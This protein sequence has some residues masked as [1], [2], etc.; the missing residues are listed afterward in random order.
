METFILYHNNPN[1]KKLEE[2]CEV[3]KVY[4]DSDKS[5][6]KDKYQLKDFFEDNR[7]RIFDQMS[8]YFRIEYIEK[9]GLNKKVNELTADDLVIDMTLP[10]PLQLII[11]KRFV[12]YTICAKNTIFQEPVSDITAFENAQIRSAIR[13]DVVR[14]LTRRDVKKQANTCSVIGFFKTLYYNKMDSSDK[15]IGASDGI[16]QTK[17]S[18]TDISKFILSLNTSVGEQGGSFSFSLP[19]VPMYH[20]WDMNKGFSS[21]SDNYKKDAVASEVDI[22]AI[23][24]EIYS[25]SGNE[26]YPVVKSQLDSMDYF[27]WLIAPNDLMFISFDDVNREYIK[28]SDMA[29]NT[30]DMIGL[31]ESVSLTRDSNGN[32]TVNVSGKDLMKLLSDD[33][34]IFFPNASVID[35]G[36]FFDNTEGSLRTG[37]LAG[38]GTVN[39]TVADK[40]GSKRSIIRMPSTGSVRLFNEECNGFTIDYIIK[41]VIMELTNMQICPSELFQSW[42]KNRTT[43]SYLNPKNEKKENV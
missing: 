14:F 28:D 19:H 22:D 10:C 15:E 41:V 40:A 25:I 33:S 7:Q 11:P 1:V 5:D 34:S 13:E 2:F 12:T 37:D 27:N 38:V 36:N 8:M 30:F 9:M 17:S 3:S 6:K 4:F 32:L 39:G 29:M 42:G 35:A 21:S 24:K 43:F 31:V 16:Y 23:T 18:F 20:L 26:E